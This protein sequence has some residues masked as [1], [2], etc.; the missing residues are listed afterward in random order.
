M[1]VYKLAETITAH[2]WNKDRTQVAI[3]PNNNE[4]IIYEVTG[5]KFVEKNRLLKHDQVVGAI[6]WCSET[7]N[8]VSCSH[9]RSAYVWSFDGEVWNPELVILPINRAALNVKWS[10]NGNKFAVCSGQKCVCVCY[11]NLKG[12][13][14]WW[15][16]RR[17]EHDSMADSVTAVDWHPNNV[18][19][20]VGGMNGNIL[21]FYAG[22]TKRGVDKKETEPIFGLGPGMRFPQSMFDIQ[23]TDGAWIQD[24]SFS[25]SGDEI[26]AVTGD[27]RIHSVNIA[28]QPFTTEHTTLPTQP[29]LAVGHLAESVIVGVGYAAD[30]IIFAKEDGMWVEK[31][32]LDDKT[33]GPVKEVKTQRNAAFAKFQA[34]ADASGKSE[35]AMKSKKITTIHKNTV[36]SLCVL[37]GAVST[38]GLD[39][40]IVVWDL[41][42]E[43]VAALIGAM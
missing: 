15:V 18:V 41:G 11:Q 33:G 7:N 35:S 8:I 19:C 2:A 5:D 27:S 23:I 37:D 14:T 25:P 21:V 24:L 1:Q 13:D 16:S 32:S 3:C 38:A 40:Q 26:V 30:P 34:A 20:A 36:R 22:I 28:A 31:H 43:A 12:D 29:L 9:D 6:D 42:V 17:F 4:I 10:P 39:G